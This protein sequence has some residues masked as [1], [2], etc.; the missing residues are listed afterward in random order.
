M[1]GNH[2]D[3]IVIGTGFGGAVTACR[4]VEAGLKVCVLERGRRYQAND[5][6]R[7]P[8]D[9]LFAS[10]DKDPRHFAPPPDFSRWLWSRDQGIYDVR[11]LGGA[12][13]V[14]SA[15]YGGGSLIYASV[16]LRP[17]ADVFD[18]GWPEQYNSAALEPYF[19]LAAYMLNVAPIPTQ[20]AKTVQLK[21]AA[22]EIA[23]PN[24]DSTWFRAPLAVNF[25][26]KGGPTFD[27][28]QGECDMRGRCWRG[29]DHQAKNTLDLNYLARVEAG[30]A[31]A[32]DAQPDIRTLADVR[33]IGHDG[34]EFRVT[35]RDMSLR[36]T[37][38][39][40]DTSRDDP[41]VHAPYVFLCAGAIGTTE[42]LFKNLG[43]LS[44]TQ[45]DALGSHYFPN[46]DSFSV[47]FDCD[48]PHE[49]D[50]G[51]TIT[52]ALRYEQKSQ[53][54]FYA[55]DFQPI[56]PRPTAA[57]R[58][59][60][61]VA[62]SPK[63]APPAVGAEV[64][65]GRSGRQ[66]ILAH[67]PILDWG[68]WDDGTAAGT[69]VV[70]ARHPPDLK[71]GD[72]LRIGTTAVKAS[73]D[74]VQ[75]THWFLVEDGGY[76][77]DLLPLVGIFRSPLWLR[78]N[79]YTEA[80]VPARGVTGRVRPERL[81]LQTFTDALGGT[82]RG[83]APRGVVARSFDPTRR[84]GAKTST[85]D[86]GLLLPGLL[87]QQLGSIFPKWFTTA[88]GDD[89]QQLVE[90]A[91]AFAL[92]MLG[93]LLD[94]LSKS[95]SDQI[96]AETRKKFVQ[97][98]V[99]GDK[100]QVLL[101]GMLRQAL[102]ILAGSEAAVATAVARL[103]LD[104]VPGTPGQLLDLLGNILLWVLDYGATDNHTGVLLTMGRDLYRGR[105]LFDAPPDNPAAGRLTARLVAASLDSGSVAQEGLLRD[106]A[107]A[108]KGE[109]RTNPAWTTLQKRVTVHS[110][111]G[112]PM[113]NDPFTSVTAPDGMVHRRPG[114][115]VMDAAAFPTSVGVNPSATI[116][117]IAEYKV[118]RFIQEHGHEFDLP[119]KDS[120][121]HVSTNPHPNKWRT[122]DKLEA[123]QWIEKVGRAVIDPINCG[124]LPPSQEPAHKPLGLIFDEAMKGF[125]ENVTELKDWLVP[126]PDAPD[127]R[128]A[129]AG[130]PKDVPRFLD[131]ENRGIRSGGEIRTELRLNIQD[132][133][134][135]IAP[136]G[137]V[138]RPRLLVCG[139]VV[140]RH[141]NSE[142]SYEVV[143][144]SSFVELFVPGAEPPPQRFFRYHLE[145]IDPDLGLR[146]LDAL[147]VL[148]DSPGADLWHDT[149]TLYFEISGG[150]GPLQRGILRVSIEDFLRVQMP[151]AEPT[152]TSD[153]ARKSWA[154]VAFYKYFAGELAAVYMER[155]DE[156]RDMLSQFFTNVY[157]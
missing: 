84:P 35:Y 33:E 80:S 115:Y 8:T 66:A 117:A 82:A 70:E 40:Q 96:D 92:P 29:C 10:S 4:L 145:F 41:A 5:F 76:P 61:D 9:E 156:F 114:L 32:L 133:A 68:S 59:D 44:L 72:T 83:A 26:Q 87:D 101:R 50:Y 146:T 129:L 98:N 73:G 77:P 152:G 104:P 31:R 120:S 154:L 19:D 71:E 13:A 85:H 150:T 39:G 131:A 54:T 67:E 25:G 127:Q 86:R 75:H 63:V 3:A 21:R 42:L 48:Q 37:S 113:G 11:D 138:P 130:F 36:D 34:R 15:G 153:P 111:G 157:V 143:K 6:P 1:D 90:Q 119:S 79:R 95:V 124:Q 107:G 43:A 81:R 58:A 136:A 97:E 125:F 151:S 121:G 46:A 17:P 94:K 144:G 89:R 116:A 91:A 148:I 12:I 22:V 105:L 109:L 16:H 100:L 69:L 55:I 123:R 99:D 112:C 108:W 7:Y 140:L 27:K 47:V 14:Q 20:L 88:L 28:P 134:R 142:T 93:R 53:G 103:A 141:S 49:A 106:I 118:E 149:A 45:P 126:D 110:Q 23:K 62:C 64:V 78:R 74:V 18:R 56:E 51:P 147:K 132:L 137:E 135:Q 30:N 139:R 57:P 102:Q 38:D 2:F 65:S 24:P 122:P 60:A 128:R 52:S 155:A